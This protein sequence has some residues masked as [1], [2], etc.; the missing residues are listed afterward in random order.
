LE[1]GV[2]VTVPAAVASPGAIVLPAR[3]LSDLVR[4][5]PPGDVELE[6]DRGAL[7]ATIHWGRSTF[8]LLGFDPEQFPLFPEMPDAAICVVRQGLLREALQRTVF[9]TAQDEARPIL[10][11]VQLTV[12][13]G[14]M[15]AV[16]TDGYRVA[17]CE[18]Q[19]T[20]VG[21]ETQEVV[22]PARSLAELVRHL[23]GGESE[24]RLVL[25]E[26]EVLFDLGRRRLRSRV[27]EGRYP[28]V[29][30]LIPSAYPSALRVE[31]QQL[32]EVCERVALI[33][34]A[35]DR[36]Q[37]ITLRLA[38]DVVVVSASASEIGSGRE[39]VPAECEGEPLEIVF[40]ARYVVDGLRAAGPGEV[41]LEFSGPTGAA[42]IRPLEDRGYFYVVMPMVLPS[43]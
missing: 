28:P 29:V 37:A 21:R 22:V 33:A 2:E 35:R 38:G 16:A 40:N 15:R 36:T 26:N 30:E 34:D 18:I 43:R 1:I 23:D 8:T 17:C 25:S 24:A 7:S 9:A 19:T 13:A 32:Q 3:H 20:E 42:R 31:A 5:I 41:V 14:T 4:R 6:V 11:G 12:T 39:E 27:L 10:T